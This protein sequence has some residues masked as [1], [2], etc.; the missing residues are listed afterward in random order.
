MSEGRGESVSKLV[1]SCAIQAR[2]V[3]K[4]AFENADPFGIADHVFPDLVGPVHKNG[5]ICGNDRLPA[6]RLVAAVAIDIDVESRFVG[7]EKHVR[8]ENRRLSQVKLMIE[9][10]QKISLIYWRAIHVM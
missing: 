3:E 7:P 6:I 2:G 9:V 5:P 4:P 10:Y 8:S 1:Y